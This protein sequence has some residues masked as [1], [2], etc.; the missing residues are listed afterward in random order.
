MKGLDVY[1]V[2][3]LVCAYFLFLLSHAG[4]VL[5]YAMTIIRAMQPMF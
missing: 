3:L 4:G 1:V 5:C 2:T